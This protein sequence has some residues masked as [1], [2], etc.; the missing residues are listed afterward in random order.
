MP[1]FGKGGGLDFFFKSPKGAVCVS[2]A[3]SLYLWGE[4]HCPALQFCSSCPSPPPPPRRCSSN[5]SIPPLP[6]LHLYPQAGLPIKIPNAQ[7]RLR[8]NVRE[9][10]NIQDLMYSKKHSLFIWHSKSPWHP[11]YLLNPPILAPRFLLLS[12]TWLGE[13]IPIFPFYS[14]RN[15][16]SEGLNTLLHAHG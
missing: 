4:S 12:S 9:A 6:A 14:W 11:F 3:H 2:T 13:V 10:C 1:A 8:L 7:L 5:S 15:K 16:G